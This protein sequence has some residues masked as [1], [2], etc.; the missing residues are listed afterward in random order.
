M[1]I[2]RALHYLILAMAFSNAVQPQAQLIVNRPLSEVELEQQH[3]ISA[4]LSTSTIDIVNCSSTS[5]PNS[6][7]LDDES[8]NSMQPGRSF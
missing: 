7:L 4:P 1:Y 3:N 8:K 5:L 6:T 2:L